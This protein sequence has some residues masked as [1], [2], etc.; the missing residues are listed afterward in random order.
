M[1]TKTKFH[2]DGTVTYWDVYRQQWV[3]RSAS[4]ILD[5][6][7]WGDM[8]LATLPESERARIARIAADIAAESA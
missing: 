4:D 3:R 7:V 8:I 1:S 5:D 6:P 2:R